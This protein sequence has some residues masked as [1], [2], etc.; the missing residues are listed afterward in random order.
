MSECN[1]CMVVNNLDVG[2]L[3]KVVISLI[4]ALDPQKYKP[5]LICLDGCGR[6]FEQAQLPAEHCLVLDKQRAFNFGVLRFDPRMLARINQFV[7]SND[8]HIVHTHNAAPLIYSGLALRLGWRRPVVIY[9]EH[10]Q[11]YSATPMGKRKFRYYVRL[12]DQLV[13]VSDDLRRTL[14]QQVKV[15]QPVRVI[16]NGIDGARFAAADGQSVRQELG[17]AADETLVGTGVVLSEQKGVPFLLTAAQQVLARQPKT[18]FV[19]AG[20][21]PLKEQLEQQAAE[22]GLGKRVLFLG[23]RSD[24][25]AVIAAFDIYVLPS[26]WEGLPLAL[27]EALAA[28]RP[29]VATAVGGSPEVVDHGINGFVIPPRDSTAMAERLLTLISD[30]D[31]RR[32]MAQVNRARFAE[33]FSLAA[34]VER[35]QELYAEV[36]RQLH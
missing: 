31:L 16:H 30:P 3:E 6:L 2:G 28:G 20:D 17:V 19:I 27:L 24:M 11:L 12:A 21:G 13:A 29:I 1:V 9:S 34:M 36:C 18:R 10:N 14:Q 35:H 26:L 7:R 4:R 5:F 15:R 22:L 8:I 33:Q 32:Q 25:P 23:Y